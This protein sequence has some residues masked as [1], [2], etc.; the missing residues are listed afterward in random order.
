MTQPVDFDPDSLSPEEKL[1]RQEI[2]KR[3]PSRERLKAIID[4]L[5]SIDPWLDDE[6]DW[7]L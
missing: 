3:T 2:M 5:P 4:R 7:D 6:Y 1:A